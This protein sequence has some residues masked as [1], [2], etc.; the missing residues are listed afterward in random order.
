MIIEEKLK[1]SPDKMI[2]QYLEGSTEVIKSLLDEN[3]L[4]IVK[5]VTSKYSN[6]SKLEWDDLQQEIHIEVIKALKKRKF[7]KGNIKSFNAWIATIARNKSIDLVRKQKRNQSPVSLNIF[8]EEDLTLLDNIAD[9]F[10]L[11]NEVEFADLI[12]KTREFVGNIDKENPKKQCLEIYNRLCQGKTQTII[13]KELK[14]SQGEVAKRRQEIGI[15]IL[16]KLGFLSE[17]QA[18][19]EINKIRQSK[20]KKCKR[21]QHRW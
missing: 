21:S 19:I 8:I 5:N 11:S 10:N 18:I 4:K 6:P 2:Q 14:I 7:N 13:A 3:Y 17:Q 1:S 20:G 9:E 16:E 15:K 12:I